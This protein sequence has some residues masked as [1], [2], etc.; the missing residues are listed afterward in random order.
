MV[1]TLREFFAIVG[2]DI[3]PPS[4]MAELFPWLF[5]V[6][7]GFVLIGFIVDLFK[8]MAIGIMSGGRRY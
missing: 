7:L 2:V 6:L 8:S 3:M 1:N 5:T 4:N